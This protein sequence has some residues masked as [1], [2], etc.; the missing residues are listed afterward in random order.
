MSW[1]RDT[2]ATDLR[3]LLEIKL[4]YEAETRKTHSALCAALKSP[5]P[6]RRDILH[7]L[8]V[9]HETRQKRDESDALYRKMREKQR[10]AQQQKLDTQRYDTLTRLAKQFTSPVDS[11]KEVRRLYEENKLMGGDDEDENNDPN[12][13]ADMFSEEERQ[14]LEKIL[15]SSA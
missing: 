13:D 7:L 11:E 5:R 6:V 3:K 8:N 2:S 9:Y 1:W 15:R 14:L 4:R 12:L 10:N